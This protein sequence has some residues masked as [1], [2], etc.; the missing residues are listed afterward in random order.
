MSIRLLSGEGEEAMECIV[1]KFRNSERNS[2]L[3]LSVTVFR[4]STG[5]GPSSRISTG[6]TRAYV[7]TEGSRQAESK[8][9]T[10]A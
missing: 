1:L 4:I 6:L 2:F 7:A 8:G 9:P 5:L 3:C 10:D